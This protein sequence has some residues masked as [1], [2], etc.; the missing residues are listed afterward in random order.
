MAGA[1]GSYSREMEAACKGTSYST[2]TVRGTGPTQTSQIRPAPLDHLLVLKYYLCWC[3]RI[4][5]TII[6][7]HLADNS[8]LRHTHSDGRKIKKAAKATLSTQ[9]GKEYQ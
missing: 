8:C 4:T 1:A 5:A 2:T 6:S 9:S 7:S 3:H